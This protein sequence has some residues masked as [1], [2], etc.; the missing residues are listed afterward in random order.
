MQSS[1]AAPQG[2]HR[3]WCRFAARDRWEPSSR[4]DFAVCR[5]S[6]AIIRFSPVNP[7]LWKTRRNSP[8]AQLS[9]S[10]NPRKKATS[11][12]RWPLFNQQNLLLFGWGNRN[13]AIQIIEFPGTMIGFRVG[14]GLL[15][16]RG[17][18]RSALLAQPGNGGIHRLV[19]DAAI[20]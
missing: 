5:D 20:L 3:I 19:K 16:Q 18:Q 15:T 17:E 6:C 1:A 10:L 11:I 9:L 8:L 13:H 14:Y 2:Y 7:Q 12:R 4:A